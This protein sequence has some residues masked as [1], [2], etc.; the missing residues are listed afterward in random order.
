MRLGYLRSF[1]GDTLVRLLLVLWSELNSSG[2]SLSRRRFLFGRNR[3]E[4]LKRDILRDLS[5]PNQCKDASGCL[6]ILLSTWCYCL[7]NFIAVY[8]TDTNYYDG[9]S[10]YCSV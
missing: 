6:F 3:P 4:V 8:L 10:I 7:G 9:S 1:L 5:K 2:P